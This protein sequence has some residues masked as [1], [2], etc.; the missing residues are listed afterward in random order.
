[1]IGKVNS[2]NLLI[3]IDPTAGSSTIVIELTP[4]SIDTDNSSY[5][6]IYTTASLTAG[7]GFGASS[8]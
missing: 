1:M 4:N 2:E 3:D 8:C 5:L 6:E 7:S